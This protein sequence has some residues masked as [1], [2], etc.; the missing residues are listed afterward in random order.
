M[1]GRAL[2]VVA[3]NGAKRVE[4]A[5]LVVEA[6]ALV[7]AAAPPAPPERISDQVKR[8]Q[9]EARGLA[10]KHVMSLKTAL[11]E[12]K[13]LAEDISSGGD[14]YPAGVREI[15]RRLVEDCEARAQAVAS[16]AMRN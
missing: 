8:L 12:L 7:E 11:E 4:P 16:L 1:R 6:V 5:P 14:V 9:A 3:D 10:H 2:K 13:V 15:A